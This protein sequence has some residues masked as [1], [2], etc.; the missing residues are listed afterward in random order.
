MRNNESMRLRVF[1]LC[2]FVS[3]SFELKKSKQMKVIRKK[4]DK[5]RRSLTVSNKIVKLKS[6][7]QKAEN[8]LP[9]KSINLGANWPQG[10]FSKV[11]P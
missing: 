9:T 8:F 6:W 1:F 2:F 11:E 5:R 4:S 10:F 3:F 7:A